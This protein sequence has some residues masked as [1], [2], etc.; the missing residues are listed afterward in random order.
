MDVNI[1]L[2]KSMLDDEYRNLN[3]PTIDRCQTYLTIISIKQE[4]ELS[5]YLYP[6]YIDAKKWI[7]CFFEDLKDKNYGYDSF[8]LEIFKEHLDNFPSPQAFRL[9]NIMKVLCIQTGYGIDDIDDK[10]SQLQFNIWKE[11]GKK[12]NKYLYLLANNTRWLIASCISFFIITTMC[13]LPAPF[14]WMKTLDIRLLE[15][16][17]EGVWHSICLYLGSALYYIAHGETDNP[18][19]SPANIGGVVFIIINEFIFWGLIINFVYQKMVNSLSKLG[20]NF[21]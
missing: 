2:I 16:Q 3:D 1:E 6:I 8:S 18:I 17:G 21:D 15:W 5:E 10:L 4:Y 19:V 7:Y 20:L 11:K 14:D 12:W 9:Y 13:F